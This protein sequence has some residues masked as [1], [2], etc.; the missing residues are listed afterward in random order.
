MNMN[1]SYDNL[2]DTIK[3]LHEDKQN[4]YFVNKKQTLLDRI[5]NYL[6]H[7]GFF[8]PEHMDHDQVRK[9][10]LDIKDYLENNNRVA[11]D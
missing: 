6:Q 5:N 8:N 3:Q 7:G 9:L 1:L 11:N 4:N 2:L 10:L